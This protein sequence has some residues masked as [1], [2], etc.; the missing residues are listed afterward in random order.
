LDENNGCEED[1][2]NENGSQ[3]EL[4]V[5]RD[6]FEDNEDEMEIKSDNEITED[7]PGGPIKERFEE[8]IPENIEFQTLNHPFNSDKDGKNRGQRM[9]ANQFN[10]E[11]TVYKNQN[12][13]K[14]VVKARPI[15]ALTNNSSNNQ[16]K[17]SSTKNSSSGGA[18]YTTTTTGAKYESQGPKNIANPF[19]KKASS[20]VLKFEPK[21]AGSQTKLESTPTSL[22]NMQLQKNS[23]TNLKKHVTSSTSNS[24]VLK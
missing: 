12:Q 8:E 17:N 23:S 3:D 4:D 13:N 2:D 16:S 20:D 18:E 21:P 15:S 5:Y 6:D 14:K 9:G 19:K 22:K 7:I 1:D 24:K 10:N 11:G